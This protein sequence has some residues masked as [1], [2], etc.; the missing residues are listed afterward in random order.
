M[1][2][3]A[4][5]CAMD[6][7]LKPFTKN[8]KQ[9]EIEFQGRSFQVLEQHL[10][11]ENLVA[12]AG[13][14]G[15]SSAELATR[16][17]VKKYQPEMLVSAGF[18]GGLVR[19]LK[20][21]CVITPDMIVDARSG[22][23]YRC[24]PM[25]DFVASGILVSAAEIAGAESKRELAERFHALAVDMEASAVAQVARDA[26]IGFFCVKAISDEFSFPML[27]LNQFVNAKGDFLTGKF[28]QWAMLRPWTWPRMIALGRNSKHA[29]KALCDW[30]NNN[31]TR[32][33]NRKINV[34]SEES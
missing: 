7:E 13:G 27:P 22:N 21:G 10:G 5:V 31:V 1:S 4:I 28:I 19:S 8:W 6:R 2:T 26:G 20:V 33:R 14:I 24:A 29:T 32:L 17:V 25:Q 18:A 16:S 23:E 34:N 3:I 12:V 11:S 9:S 15:T 30:L